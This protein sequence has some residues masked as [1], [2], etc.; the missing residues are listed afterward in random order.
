MDFCPTLKIEFNSA[1]A[2][3]EVILRIKDRIEPKN[4]WKLVS[5]KKYIGTVGK[6]KFQIRKQFIPDTIS[7]PVIRGIVES[8]ENESKITIIVT[9]NLLLTVFMGFWFGFSLLAFIFI[10]IEAIDTKEFSWGLLIPFAIFA[11][12]YFIWWVSVVF[13]TEPDE[14]LIFDLLGND[15]M[16][17][18]CN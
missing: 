11:F 4:S 14:V 13:G 18:K 16:S 17:V 3:E 7:N 10:L 1:L 15:S 5:N 6:N 12:G 2:A 8:R 9:P